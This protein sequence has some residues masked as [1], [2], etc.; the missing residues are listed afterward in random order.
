MP[1][2]WDGEEMAEMPTMEYK[3]PV[4]RR[5]KTLCSV[6]PSWEAMQEV[7]IRKMVSV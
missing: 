1:L 6:G 2:A 7:R 3:W 5:D 4:R